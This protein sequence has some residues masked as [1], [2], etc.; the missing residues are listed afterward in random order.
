MRYRF[1]VITFLFSMHFVLAAPS[2]VRALDQGEAETGVIYDAARYRTSG[3]QF[4]ISDLVGFV[5]FRQYLTNY[6]VLEGRL[7]ASDSEQHDGPGSLYK[8]Q[9]TYERLTLRDFHWGSSVLR[10]S[11]GDQS[12][13]ISNLPVN[14]SN[15][16]YP[17]VYFRGLSLGVSNPY[18]QME[19]M[20]GGMTISR[21]LLGET[22]Q[23]TGEDVYGVAARAQPSERLTVEGDFFLTNNEKNYN[24]ELITKSNDVYRLAADLRTWSKL[25]LLGE[26][27]Q[28][29]SVDP[30]SR[31]VE[32]I[33]YRG[34]AIWRGDQLHL[35]G[36]YR[37]SGPDFHLLGQNYQYDN[38]VKGFYAA[39]DYNPWPF[40]GISGSFDSAEHNLLIDPAKS[41]N[42]SESRSF[43][44]RFYRPPW[45]SL[46]WRY[47]SGDL[48]SRGDFPVAV[49][50]LN[51]GQYVE[52]SK[53]FGFVDAYVRYEYFQYDDKVNPGQ[54]YQKSSPLVGVRASFS[55]F[56]TYAEAE[57]DQFS[58]ASQG[59]GSDGLYVKTGGSYAFSEK[60]FLY[61]EV[62]YRPNGEH[63]GGQ[64]GINWELPYGFSFRAFGQ[65]QTGKAGV[66]DF[67]NDYTS[68]Q[69]SVRLVKSFSW[70]EKTAAAGVRS[71]QEWMGTGS[72][73]GW[74]FDDKNLNGSIDRDEKGVE[75]IKVKLEDG[76][77]VTTD[78]DGR[79]CFPS[80]GSGKH[81]VILDAARIP[82]AYTFIASE[83]STVE[84]KNRGSAR[85]DFPFILGS[86]IRGRVL[87]APKDG[88]T[89]VAAKG[90][91][92]VLVVLKPGD[93]NTYT[94]A[95]GGYSFESIVPRQY[96]ISLAQETLPARAEVLSP[97]AQT[98]KLTPGDRVDAVEFSL[99]IRERRV[100]FEGE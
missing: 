19:I 99:R 12:F 54:S 1:G 73:E 48:A 79:Y 46:Y 59:Q 36:N 47:Y 38:N 43:G 98:V 13:R 4:F 89:E 57:Y 28:S 11:I 60:L 44:L 66:G 69:V 56:T 68:N 52:L 16:F 82:A 83:T 55:K 95:N 51:Q 87:A 53:P 27:M 88:N 61:G 14:F 7:A 100:V 30:D 49:H 85:V 24:G 80:V 20:G 84:V 39:G 22:F 40:L 37:Y 78:K 26:F 76:S 25:Y 72:I 74:V 5:D 6:G 65:A 8:D 15:Y 64:V 67:V 18:V 42:E 50:G 9:L 33:A 63:F 81:V 10:A 91:P 77:T 71:G 2:A 58:P 75:G 93:I 94:D 34:G 86:S 32:D 90:V 35:E 3:Q 23:E 97:Q 70:G 92:D 31:K 41:I 45:P 17:T 62:N 96:E 21:G 29:F